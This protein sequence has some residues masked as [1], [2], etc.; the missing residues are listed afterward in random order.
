VHCH[1]ALSSSFADAVRPG[2][3]VV[4]VGG[5]L[6][7]GHLVTVLAKRGVQDIKLVSRWPFPSGDRSTHFD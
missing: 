7:S 1:Q 5:G 4:V 2:D 3:R 6:T